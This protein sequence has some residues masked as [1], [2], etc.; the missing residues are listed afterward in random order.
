MSNPRDVVDFTGIDPLAL[1]FLIDD[2]TITYDKN[3]VGGS[4]QVGLAV[5]MSDD[6][7]V[8]L[9]S[10]NGRVLGRLEKVEADKKAVVTVG[11][12]VK[13]PRGTGATVTPGSQIK[14]DLLG[15]AKG[16]VQDAAIG[17]GDGRVLDATDATD[18]AEVVV[19]L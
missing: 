18:G 2:S 10:D 3:K 13:L 9:V 12:C 16:Y 11:G 1:T 17:A 15:A 5:E 7:T 8:A 6:K 19:L 4:A 14:G